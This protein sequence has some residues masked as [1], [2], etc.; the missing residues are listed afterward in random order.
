MEYFKKIMRFARPYWRFIG[1]NIAFNV[2][3]ALFSALS[4]VALIPMLEVLF[5][6]TKKVSTPPTYTGLTN[7]KFYL[8]EWM[9]FQVSSQ[10]DQNPQNALLFSIGLILVLFFLKNLFNYLALYFITFL[11]NGI[12]KDLRNALYHKIRKEK[13]RH[14]GPHYSRCT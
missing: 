13:R 1:L 9:N 11:R 8:T 12:L 6:T 5:G 4:F 7:L 14:L 10:V 3:Y 2:L